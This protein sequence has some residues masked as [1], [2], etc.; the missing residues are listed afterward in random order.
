M[1]VD[2]SIKTFRNSIKFHDIEITES[3][4]LISHELSLL[5]V[6][7]SKITQYEMQDNSKLD[8]SKST[9]HKDTKIV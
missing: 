3:L 8:N 5:N 7:D 6:N 1:V 2:I 4:L 9:I